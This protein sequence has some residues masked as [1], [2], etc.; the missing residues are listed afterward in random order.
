VKRIGADWR[1]ARA[2]VTTQRTQRP[3]NFLVGQIAGPRISNSIP[4]FIVPTPGPILY[5]PF[6]IVHCFHFIPSLA[7]IPFTLNRRRVDGSTPLFC[8]VGAILVGATFPLSFVTDDPYITYQYAQNLI[9]G[10]N[11]FVFNA[12]EHAEHD[13]AV[14]CAL[15]LAVRRTGRTGIPVLGYWVKASP[16]T[17]HYCAYFFVYRIADQFD[18]AVGGVVAR[19]GVVGRTSPR[20]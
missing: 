8:I 15:L 19:R 6:S 12:G 16:V 14:V 17:G 1:A 20:C 11:G 18:F 5:C 9:S 13:D 2:K 4:N 10:R 7:T 3:R